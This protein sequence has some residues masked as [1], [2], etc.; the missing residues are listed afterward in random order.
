[1]LPNSG[2]PQMD[3]GGGANGGGA[4]GEFSVLR[5]EGECCGGSWG[6]EKINLISFATQCCIRNQYDIVK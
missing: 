4:N 2:I 6:W 3:E 5:V 1:M